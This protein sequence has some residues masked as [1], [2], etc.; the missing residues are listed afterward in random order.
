M[1]IKNTSLSRYDGDF[2]S[3]INLINKLY[4]WNKTI[5]VIVYS[6]SGKMRYADLNCRKCS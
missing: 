6:M 4:I 1:S 5:C 2:T 3:S